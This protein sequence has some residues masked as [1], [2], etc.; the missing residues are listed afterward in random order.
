[1][2]FSCPNKNLPE[3]KKLVL[4]VGKTRAYELYTEN[5]FDIPTQFKVH[6]QDIRRVIKLY[7]NE[8]GQDKLIAIKKALDRYNTLNNTSHK[9]DIVPVGE[10]AES[11]VTLIVDFSKR[12]EDAYLERKEMRSEVD[13]MFQELEQEKDDIEVFERNIDYYM[14]DKQLM[15]QEEGLNQFEST[16]TPDAK[17]EKTIKDWLEKVGIK[18]SAIDKIYDSEGNEVS[19]VAKAN[20]VAKLIEVVESK[21]GIDTLPEEAGHMLVR[22]LGLEHPLVKT[23]MQNVSKYKIYQDVLNSTYGD[24]YSQDEAKLREEAVGKVIAQVLVAKLTN[25]PIE[26]ELRKEESRVMAIWK[27][28]VNRLQ[29]LI[30]TRAKEELAEFVSAANIII[31]NTPIEVSD[32]FNSSEFTG[33]NVFYQLDEETTKGVIGKLKSL[34]VYYNV[35]EKAYFDKSGRRIKNRVTDLVKALEAKRYKKKTETEMSPEAKQAAAAGTVTH[36]YFKEVTLR[37]LTQTQDDPSRLKSTKLTFT[38]IQNT[39]MA[40]L[41]QDPEMVARGVNFIKSFNEVHFNEVVADVKRRLER[42]YKTQDFINKETKTKGKVEILPEFTI[43]NPSKD[44]A[45]TIDLL[46]IY[47]NGK[48]SIYDY[49]GQK[50]RTRGSQVL[51]DFRSSKIWSGNEQISVY[52]DVLRNEFGIEDFLETRLIPFNFQFNKAGNISTIQVGNVSDSREYLDEVPVASELTGIKELDAQLEKMYRERN[53]LQS[54]IDSDYKNKAL[55]LRMDNLNKSIQNLIINRDASYVYNEVKQIIL[56]FQKRLTRPEAYGV[57]HYYLNNLL[58]YLSIYDD[59]FR[60]TKKIEQFATTNAEEIAKIER[61]YNDIYVDIKDSIA[62]ANECNKTLLEKKYP[63]INLDAPVKEISFLG[64]MF[65][66]LG[67]FNRAQFKILHQIVSLQQRYVKEETLKLGEEL[68]KSRDALNA[69]AK[70]NNLSLQQAMDKLIT[71]NGKSLVSRYNGI[72]GEEKTKAIKNKDYK[73]FE[74]NT[75]IKLGVIGYEYAN[76]E[77][78]NKFED[79]KKKAFKQIEESNVGNP[80]RIEKLKT[81]WETSYDITVNKDAIFNKPYYIKAVWHDRFMSDIWKFMNQKGNEPLLNAYNLLVETNLKLGEIT[82]R[83]IK[84]GFIPEIQKG[85]VESLSNWN[86]G[87]EGIRDNIR[88]SF[89]VREENILL[90]KRDSNTGEVI[91]SIPL[92]FVDDLTISLSTSELE[93]LK[94]GLVA[95]GLLEGSEEFITTLNQ[96]VYTKERG[97]GL[98]LKSRDLFTSALLFAESAYTHAYSQNVEEEVKA[99]RGTLENVETELSAPNG[100]KLMDKV[101]GK[102]AKV[103]GAPKDEIEALDKF[104][105]L[106][107]Y[108]QSKQTKDIV[109]EG[110]VSVTKTISQAMRGT[111]LKALGGSWIVAAGSIFGASSNLIIAASEG[112]YYNAAQVR[113]A[114]QLYIGRENK[115]RVNAFLEYFQPFTHNAIYEKSRDLSSSTTKKFLNEDI[116]YIMM[117]Y[118]DKGIDAINMLAILQNFGIDSQG[119]IRRVNGSIKSIYDSITIKNGEIEGINDAQYYALRNLITTSSV[120]LKGNMFKDDQN[121]VGT[122][123]YTA[124]VM[125][126]RNWM[127]GLIESR[128]RQLSYDEKIDDLDVGRFRV[129]FGEFTAKGLMPKLG[130]FTK[131]ATEVISLGMYKAL[132]NNANKAVAEMYFNKF[133]EQNPE[134]RNKITLDQFIELRQQKLRGMAMELRILMLLTLIVQLL[135]AAIPDDDDE[136]VQEWI[137]KNA[138]RMTNRGLLEVMFFFDP[139]TIR[140]IAGQPLPILKSITELQKFLSNTVDSGRDMLTGENYKGVFLWGKDKN[141]QTPPLYYTSK[142][143]PT[144]AVLDIIDIFGDNEKQLKR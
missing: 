55:K 27:N 38:D 139:S 108:G 141:D 95:K 117:K 90:G 37:L 52:R 120:R 58:S 79:L 111:S 119:R 49:K 69:W 136:V 60:E 12:N 138:Y 127:P 44:L 99:L 82:D 129:L 70:S 96:L 92:L 134:L 128:F 51:E 3:W 56:D 84:E 39:V 75:Q 64:S 81:D 7:K 86:M 123:I 93:E 35:K 91:P 28:I 102:I 87:L 140:Q 97:K 33:E 122:N 89:K 9:L 21:R 133:L 61:K 112:K 4:A 74:Q 63:D 73:W 34:G 142:L 72:Y 8:V 124:M 62:K 83:E 48:M 126:F 6:L 109:T 76:K 1:M 77:D 100:K 13:K 104:I 10:S 11:R 114:F 113:K 45:G 22:M 40:E 103:V 25:T 18:Y 31:E 116:F 29:R 68:E 132:S 53:N 125:Q 5:N 50:Y 57:N 121:L 118:P 107:I 105:K 137:T 46:V 30:G 59:F 43:Y 24:I 32:K 135:A 41:M 67:Q 85:I 17:I 20:I 78:A 15:E 66:R 2:P 14:G 71:S 101:T 88:T 106:H 42:I 98:L 65:T 47:S 130:T 110:G 16:G 131:L 23:M 19:A 115:E 80:K 144:R 143:L 54:K 94:K 26:L 36:A